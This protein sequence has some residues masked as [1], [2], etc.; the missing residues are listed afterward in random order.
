[1]CVCVCF[2]TNQFPV[3]LRRGDWCMFTDF[4]NVLSVLH[5]KHSVLYG[6][7]NSKDGSTKNI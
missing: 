5:F 6:L 3:F 1:V 2:E 4:V 7:R